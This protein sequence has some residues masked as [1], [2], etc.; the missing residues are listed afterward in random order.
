MFGSEE[1]ERLRLRKELLVLE[2]DA[3]RVLL[4]SE[5]QRWRSPGFWF[6]EAGQVARRHPWLTAALGVGAGIAVIRVVRQPRRALRWLGGPVGVISTLQV[7]RKF[8]ARAS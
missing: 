5:W 6:D 7:I 1:L 3:R 4:I 2:C 8:F